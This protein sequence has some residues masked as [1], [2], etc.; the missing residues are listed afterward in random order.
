M[1]TKLRCD[2]QPAAAAIPGTVEL[3][4]IMPCL[5]EAAT[6]EACI[7]SAAEFLARSNTSG[8]IVVGD[9]GST[10]GS[11]EIAIRMGARVVEVPV[12]GYGA[13]I[14]G[15]VGGSRGTYCVMGDSDGSYDFG[16]LEE[17]L[18]L[19]RG[20][21]DLV[22]G[23]RFG[24]GIAPGAMPWK[25]R[26][27]GNPLFSGIGRILFRCSVR[28][29]H[30]GLRGF[31]RS[32]FQRMDLRTT[33][34]EF[35]SEMVVKAA[36]MKMTIAEVPTTLSPDGR[37]RPPH[38]RP[39]RDGLRHLRFMMLCSPDWIFLYSGLVLMFFGL[40]VGSF[41]FFRPI[42]INNVQ[43]GI[44]SMIYC[45]MLTGV[46]FQ[47]L[48]FTA[49]SRTFG[50]R[51]GLFPNTR[52]ADALCHWLKLELAIPMAGAFVAAGAILGIH[53]LSIWSRADFG[54]L[55]AST[56]ARNVIASSLLISLGLELFLSSCLLGI[57]QLSVRGAN[58]HQK[59]AQG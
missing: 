22:M 9:N 29:F 17:F 45:A 59:D 25:N 23:D 38:L 34:M 36:L 15:A 11:Q 37:S 50:A 24:G 6:L 46:G 53:A 54:Y 39:Y 12:K 44:N 42:H 18:R 14:Y 19:L 20:G 16:H 52:L 55:N 35:A 1:L 21:A 3:S 26:Y 13:A 4:I 28:D 31:S 56:F 27:I 5:N 7:R 51:E 49:L 48:L 57:I 41:L 40:I 30:C 32:A 58:R 47:A 10:D 33:G 8:E 43:F 2:A